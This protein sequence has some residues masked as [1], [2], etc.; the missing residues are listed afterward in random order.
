MI[1]DDMIITN[2]RPLDE[3]H[4]KRAYD[5]AR[6]VRDAFETARRRFITA[7]DRWPTHGWTWRPTPRVVLQSELV[8]TSSVRIL[9]VRTRSR[10]SE[11]MIPEPEGACAFPDWLDSGTSRVHASRAF[12]HASIV[13]ELLSR[14]M[15]EG[16]IPLAK[17]KAMLTSSC[18]DQG[19]RSR[20]DAHA[21]QIVTA[22][23]PWSPLYRRTSPFGLERWT[24][25]RDGRDWEGVRSAATID[26]HSDAAILGTLSSGVFPG[27]PDP[28]ATLRIHSE[29]G[30]TLP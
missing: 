17:A 19:M 8:R 5:A 15:E 22:R 30:G 4:L 13:C 11:I 18:L 28:I 9:G 6:R 7:E 23:S 26:L 29:A 1:D 16:T 27:D 3:A 20:E 10:R 21:E 14:A 12:E 25:L 2:A 24:S